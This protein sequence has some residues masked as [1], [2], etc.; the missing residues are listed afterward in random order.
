MASLPGHALVYDEEVLNQL[1]DTYLAE[2]SLEPDLQVLIRKLQVKYLNRGRRMFLVEFPV[3]SVKKINELISRVAP[4]LDV[5][6]CLCTDN[7]LKLSRKV[8]KWV[9]SYL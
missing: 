4:N 1:L 7:G 9:S 8:F 3:S 5:V 6:P 2:F